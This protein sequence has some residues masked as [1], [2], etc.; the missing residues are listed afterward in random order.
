MF[1]IFCHVSWPVSRAVCTLSMAS[2]AFSRAISIGDDSPARLT[3]TAV[4]P[5]SGSSP[6]DQDHHRDHD[7]DERDR[8]VRRDQLLN[9]LVPLHLHVRIRPVDA[10]DRHRARR[11]DVA[12]A[13]RGKS[14]RSTR[15]R[16]NR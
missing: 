8:R 10:E 13:R 12:R 3:A 15:R 6:T 1:W 14:F 9:H 5:T 2:R 7:F 4:T 11:L 16:S